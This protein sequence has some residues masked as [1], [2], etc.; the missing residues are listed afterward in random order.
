[1]LLALAIIFAIIL[2]FWIGGYLDGRFGS[3]CNAM[4]SFKLFKQMH[5]NFP[6]KWKL[7]CNYA[8]FYYESPKDATYH[9][10]YPT[11]EFRGYFSFFDL[12]KY[13]YY[14][15]QYNH[16]IRSEREDKDYAEVVKAFSDLENKIGAASG[17]FDKVEN[18][19]SEMCKKVQ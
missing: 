4:I 15:C 10:L 17:S 8:S 3:G 19:F 6:Q 9:E 5:R 1:M 14:S 18:A 2:V 13:W 12:P 7:D 11:K 16:Q